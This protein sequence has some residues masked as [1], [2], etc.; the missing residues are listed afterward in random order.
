MTL[1]EQLKSLHVQLKKTSKWPSL[2]MFK[3]VMP[4]DESTV[5]QVNSL[6][7]STGN[8]SY[9]T[10]KDGRYIAVTNVA[11]MPSAKSVVDVTSNVAKVPNVMIL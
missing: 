2:Y 5:Q 11:R 10:S 8:T 7:P 6:L 1:E 9:K 4:N 3:F